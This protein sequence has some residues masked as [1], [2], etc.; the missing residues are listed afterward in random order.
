[1][2]FCAQ[3]ASELPDAIRVGCG[4]GAQT[5]VHMS[6]RAPEVHLDGGR[7]ER[8]G[9]GTARAGDQ[10]EGAGGQAA[11]DRPFDAVRQISHALF[12]VAPDG[13]VTTYALARRLLRTQFSKRKKG[14]IGS[15][16]GTSSA[17][18]GFLNGEAAASRDKD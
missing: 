5:M 12:S 14:G 13:A 18:S 3:A 1:M 7:S 4:P 8:H 15:A 16:A 17:D 10:D 6:E 2:E 9:V 11:G